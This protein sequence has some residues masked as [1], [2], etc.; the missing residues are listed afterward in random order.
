MARGMEMERLGVRD[1][2][3]IVIGDSWPMAAAARSAVAAVRSPSVQR[4]AGKSFIPFAPES[5]MRSLLFTLS[6]ALFLAGAAQAAAPRM[7]PEAR[8]ARALE[9]R[10]AGDP[11]DC[12]TLRSIRS[13][14][15]IDGT[16]ILYEGAGGTLYVNRPRSGAESLDNWDTLVTDTR[17]SQLCSIDVVRLYD[18]SARM[19]TGFVSLGSF[20]P[21]RKV[22]D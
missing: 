8:L 12:L 15:I 19:Q 13:S 2:V 4:L 18:T 10:V 1:L 5:F 14:R 3:P 21:Y 20:V 7:E 22:R 6:A 9:G 16:A 11:V 17:S